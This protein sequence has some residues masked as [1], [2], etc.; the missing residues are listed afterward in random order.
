M[1]K[2]TWELQSADSEDGLHHGDHEVEPFMAGRCPL[3]AQPGGQGATRKALVW[4]SPAS[5]SVACLK[6]RAGK[7]GRSGVC[8][9]LLQHLPSISCDVRWAVQ[10]EAAN[11]QHLVFAVEVD[12]KPDIFARTTRGRAGYQQEQDQ[13]SN[14]HYLLD[15]APAQ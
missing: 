14:K 8:C 3:L 4:L 6:K 5:L 13:D 1:R 12:A 10:A 15:P 2:K 9:H 11:L 7:V